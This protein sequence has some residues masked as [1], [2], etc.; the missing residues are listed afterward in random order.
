MTVLVE[1]NDLSLLLNIWNE[2]KIPIILSTASKKRPKNWEEKAIETEKDR[3]T[4]RQTE[5]KQKWKNIEIVRW[6]ERIYFA[7][8]V[9]LGQKPGKKKRKKPSKVTR[10]KIS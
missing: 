4:D 9:T 3:Q 5:E 6:I 10:K 1:A 2:V 7:L 8:F